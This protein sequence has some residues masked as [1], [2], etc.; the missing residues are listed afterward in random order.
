M[1]GGNGAGWSLQGLVYIHIPADSLHPHSTI[2][3]IGLHIGQES[4]LRAAVGL[5]IGLHMPNRCAPHEALIQKFK[6]AKNEPRLKLTIALSRAVGVIADLKITL[7][8]FQHARRGSSCT[9]ITLVP[10]ER[11]L[12]KDLS[13]AW[14]LR[15][16]YVFFTLLPCFRQLQSRVCPHTGDNAPRCAAAAAS[17]ASS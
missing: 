7:E 12:I 17:V 15:P 5:C 8:R 10:F 9:H 16:G 1:E 6:L 14:R 4:Y 11:W 3:S 13:G 2:Q